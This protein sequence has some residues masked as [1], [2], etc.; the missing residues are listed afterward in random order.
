[1]QKSSQTGFTLLEAMVVVS[2]IGI[3]VAIAVPSYRDQMAKSQLSLQAGSVLNGLQLARSE[4]LRRNSKVFFTIGTD[5]SWTVGCETV[6]GDLNGDGLPDCPSIIQSKAAGEGGST[7][8][9]S[10]TPTTSRTAT[11]T[12]L[13]L[14]SLTNKDGSVPF[15]TLN[16]SNTGTTKT[17][18]ITLSSGGQPKLC[19]PSITTAGDPNLC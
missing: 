10:I 16:F 1:M 17:S 3:L 2:I 9:M 19:D 7:V 14:L 8:A 15:T 4:A 18:R 12:G 13:S 5:L 6:V 11:F